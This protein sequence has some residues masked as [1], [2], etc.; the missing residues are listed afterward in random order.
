MFLLLFL[1][2]KAEVEAHNVSHMPPRSR[3]SACVR[4]RGLSLG[5]QKVDTKIKEAKQVPTFS[6]DCER[7]VLGKGALL[8]L[9]HL[10]VI[11][12]NENTQYIPHISKL[13]WLTSYAMKN[14][15]G[16]DNTVLKNGTH[17]K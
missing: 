9:L 17:Q 7:V 8:P 13:P 15:S 14:Q 10:P 5:H 3:C 16:V 4:G 6:V 1:L 12:H 2:S 11:P